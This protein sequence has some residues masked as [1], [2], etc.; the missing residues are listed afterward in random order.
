MIDYIPAYEDSFPY[1]SHE[2]CEKFKQLLTRLGAKHIHS[3]GYNDDMEVA[4][5]GLDARFTLS[6]SV[7]RNTLL[8]FYNDDVYRGLNIESKLDKLYQ[9]IENKV[10]QLPEPYRYSLNLDLAEHYPDDLFYIQMTINDSKP[11]FSKSALNL[12]I[13]QEDYISHE[14]YYDYRDL[15]DLGNEYFAAIFREWFR[16]N[17]HSDRIQQQI[18]RAQKV[19]ELKKVFLRDNLYEQVIVQQKLL[20]LLKEDEQR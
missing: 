16:Q 1:E 5:V 15:M 8:E 19:D 6:P 12:R 18:Q 20:A 2:K 3:V 7:F 9:H 17:V 14:M 10:K 4:N 13:A 11:R